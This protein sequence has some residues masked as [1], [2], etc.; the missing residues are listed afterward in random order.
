[1]VS[2]SNESTKAVVFSNGRMLKD[3]GFMLDFIVD[4]VFWFLNLDCVKKLIKNNFL[5]QRSLMS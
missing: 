1:M 3:K 5:T 4:A 2:V